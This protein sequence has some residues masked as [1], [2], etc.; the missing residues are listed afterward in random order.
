MAI[1]FLFL[2]VAVEC[3]TVTYAIGVCRSH[4]WPRIKYHTDVRNGLLLQTDPF[5]FTVQVNIVT[6]TNYLVLE[7]TLVKNV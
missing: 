5:W 4:G 2:H 3:A 1:M 7:C 6:K